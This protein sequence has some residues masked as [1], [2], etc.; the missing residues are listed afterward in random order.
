LTGIGGGD[1]AR[2]G[3]KM[4]TACPQCSKPISLWQVVKA[5]TPLHVRCPHCLR[6]LR[7]KNLTLLIVV[8]GLALGVLLGQKLL[9]Q[10]RIEGGLPVRGLLLA[11]V[12]VVGFDL[13]ASFAIVNVGKLAPRD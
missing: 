8:A 2:Q 12:I 6:P 1:Y 3:M 7:A 9:E 10:A 5:P 13:L 4:A 11:L